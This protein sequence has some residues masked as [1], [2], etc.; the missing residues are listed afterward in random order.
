M[1]DILEHCIPFSFGDVLDKCTA[2]VDRVQVHHGFLGKR[3]QRS[4]QVGF[5]K[6]LKDKANDTR[7]AIPNVFNSTIALLSIE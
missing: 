5:L 6:E 7:K 2:I 1:Y 4:I 3:R